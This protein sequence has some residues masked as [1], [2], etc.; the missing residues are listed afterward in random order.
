MR[1][2]H[3]I[4]AQL[5]QTVPHHTGYHVRI[6]DRPA[7]RC[8]IALGNGVG[9]VIGDRLGIQNLDVKT[10]AGALPGQVSDDHGVV[11]EHAIVA[12]RVIRSRTILHIGVGHGA[13]IVARDG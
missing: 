2:G 7:I 12:S 9:I 4:S 6:Q 13:G 1:D 11:V 8:R 5:I 10:V 3:A